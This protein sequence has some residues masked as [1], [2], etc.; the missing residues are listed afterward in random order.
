MT[1][2]IFFILC[3][4]F[5]VFFKVTDDRPVSVNE[6]AP[7]VPES[8]CVPST[9]IRQ[10]KIGT[11]KAYPSTVRATLNKKEIL[12]C[13]RRGIVSLSS[14]SEKPTISVEEL[15]ENRRRGMS[16]AGIGKKLGIDPSKEEVLNVF[17]A[18][19]EADSDIPNIEEENVTILRHYPTP[20]WFLWN[21]E[22]DIIAQES[23]P[24]IDGILAMGIS[25]RVLARLGEDAA[26]KL[27]AFVEVS[28]VITEEVGISL[29]NVDSKSQMGKVAAWSNNLQSKVVHSNGVLWSEIGKAA[30]Q[31]T[32]L[33][34]A[35]SCRGRG[36]CRCGSV[37]ALK[38]SW[39]SGVHPSFFWG[40]KLYTKFDQVRHDKAVGLR[41]QSFEVVISST[42]YSTH[43][44]QSDLSRME[45]HLD[46]AKK[47][48]TNESSN[49]TDTREVEKAKQVFGESFP[50]DMDARENYF[51]SLQEKV[52]EMIAHRF[53]SSSPVQEQGEHNDD[54]TQ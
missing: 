51:A 7:T 11:A 47:Y 20:L 39:H 41:G 27:S 45:F 53:K 29:T 52:V 37:K 2:I 13:N 49:T 43:L 26:V 9:T 35:S 16:Y 32:P 24:S 44:L 18:V 34:D 46:E 25:S 15:L 50:T 42:Q 28:E 54:H 40:C 48:Y 33:I 22:T 19:K 1:I 6:T 38:C 14:S 4:T 30:L 12:R 8:S 5:C 3:T 23:V 17:R 10:R 21:S 36:R 31:Q